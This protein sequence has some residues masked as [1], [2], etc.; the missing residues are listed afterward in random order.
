MPSSGWSHAPAGYRCP[1]CDVATVRPT[2]PTWSSEGDIV[3][4]DPQVVA[5]VAARWRPDNPGHVLVIPCAHVENVYDLTDEL[6]VPLLRTVRSVARAMKTAYHC[7]GITVRQN[8]EPAGSQDVW[9]YHQHVIPRWT[10]DRYRSLGLGDI[11]P[12]AERA[13]YADRLRTALEEH[14]SGGA[15]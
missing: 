12:P 4:H 1:F 8:N 3:L 11:R 10:G 9:H 13:T 15:G 14:P 6:A 5:F 2:P 7:D